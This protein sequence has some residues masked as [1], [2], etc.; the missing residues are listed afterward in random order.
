MVNRALIS[1]SAF[2][3][4]TVTS[5]QY[6]V[7]D[8]GVLPGG[9]RSYAFGIN[10]FGVVA[11]FSHTPNGA[12]AYLWDSTQGMRDLGVLRQDYYSFALSVNSHGVTTGYSGNGLVKTGFDGGM[13]GLRNIGTYGGDPDSLA[14]DINDA[15]QIVGMSGSDMGSKRAFLY[16]PVTGM[17]DLGK[18]DGTSGSF[19]RG[20]NENGMVV[21]HSTDSYSAKAFAWTAATGMYQL[22]NLEGGNETWATDVND[23]GTAV[24]WATDEH[25]VR[26]AVAWGSSQQGGNK[27][28]RS[29][30]GSSGGTLSFDSAV[31]LAINNSGSIVGYGTNGGADQ[32]FFYSPNTGATRLIDLVDSSGAGWNLVHAEDINASGQ[33]VGYGYINGNLHGFVATPVPEPASALV[34]LSGIAALSLRKRRSK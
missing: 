9:D 20:I 17:H 26:H 15:G 22:K 29:I 1:I 19:A 13:G 30:G 3:L 27:E 11:G 23:A 16:D 4:A 18:L 10:D 24:G 31:A 6:H 34:I 25:G 14:I 12:R 21:G 8:L 32:A 28:P 33:I 2:A 7:T 5:A